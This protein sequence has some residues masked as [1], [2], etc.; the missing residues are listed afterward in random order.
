MTNLRRPVAYPIATRSS[1]MTG[2]SSVESEF[3]ALRA[4]WL[5]LLLNP[6]QAWLLVPRL[7]VAKLRQH[8]HQSGRSVLMLT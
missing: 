5:P 2:H 7:P 8:E 3:D 1:G 6:D 4:R